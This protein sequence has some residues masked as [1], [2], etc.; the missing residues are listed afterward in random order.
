M[1][2]Q[3]QTKPVGYT[4]LANAIIKRAANDYVSALRI[5]AQP[6]PGEDADVETVTKYEVR[7]ARAQRRIHETEQF[8][9]SDWFRTLTD[10]DGAWMMTRLRKVRRRR[11]KC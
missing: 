8:F 9:T 7:K 11:R 3:N 1:N 6:A 2:A 5:L 10:V 4:A